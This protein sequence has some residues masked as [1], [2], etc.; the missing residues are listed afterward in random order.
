M[1]KELTVKKTSYKFLD[2]GGEMGELIR[3]INWSDNVLGDPSEWPQTLRTAVRIMLDSPFGMY[4]A[5]GNEYTQLY[6]DG[7][8]PILGTKKHPSAMGRGTRETF[9][10][11]CHI[12]GPMF[13]GVMN[14]TPVGFPDFMLPLDRNGYIEECYFDF[15]YSPI[16]LENGAVG[17]VFVTVIETT[18]RVKATNQLNESKDQLQFAIEAAELATWD[19]NPS[20]NKFKGNNRLKEW[21]GLLPNEEIELPIAIA[22]IAEKDRERVI[23][24]IQTAL[25]FSSG[26]NY[27]VEYTI[28]NPISKKERIVRAKGKTV[29]NQAQIPMRFNGTLQDITEEVSARQALEKSEKEFHQLADSLPQ[30]VWTTN[31]KGHQL[32]ASKRWEEYSGIMPTGAETWG[33]NSASRRQRNHCQGME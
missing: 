6:N 12:I 32:F 30:L 25:E 4:I 29:F 21:F 13:D 18:E 7:Y 9:S 15:S 11:I 17:G 20:T 2:G 8:R 27:N 23:K 14:G 1:E 24:A 16:Q 26:G 3:S 19:L 28:V 5:W 31:N 10:E 22:A 33:A